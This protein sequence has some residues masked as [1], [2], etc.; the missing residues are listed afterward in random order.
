MSASRLSFLALL[1]Y[2]F[3][4]LPLAV[5]L[6]ET[7]YDAPVSNHGARVRLISK[8][9]KL[10]LQVKSPADIGG[11]KSAEY[12]KLSI[13]VSVD[14]FRMDL[15]SVLMYLFSFFFCCVLL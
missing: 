9:K 1:C 5:G 2:S 14:T 7:L 6:L 15:S 4:A 3:V 10:D 13:Q 8:L 12:S 11:L